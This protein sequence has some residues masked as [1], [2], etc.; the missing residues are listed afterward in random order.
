MYYFHLFFFLFCIISCSKKQIDQYNIFRY[1]EANSIT[2]LDPIFSNTQSNIWA[3]NQIFNTLVELDQNL[4]V[5]PSI[6]KKWIQSS[7]GLKYTFIIHDNIY[8]H[9]SHCFGN[10]STRKLVA[11]DF[12][13]SISRLYDKDIVSPGGW[14]LDYIDLENTYAINDTMIEIR[15]KQPFP[16][17]LGLLSMNYFSFTPYE[18]VEYY[19]D[20]F[21]KNP[22]G[23]GPFKFK[24]WKQNEKLI[25][26]KNLNYF[27]YE[28]NNR[29]PYLDG[30]AISFITQKE[31]VFMNLILGNFDFVSG[32]DSSFKDEFL[33]QNGELVSEYKNQFYLSKTPYLNTEYLGINIS[34]AKIESSLLADKNYRK[35]LNYSFDRALM[36][37]YLRN[38]IVTAA[39]SGIV[40]D[41]LS[42]CYNVDG[43]FYSPD[44]VEK[45]LSRIPDFTKSIT[46][47]T[48][49]DYLDVCEFIQHSASKFGINIDIEISSPAI[50]RE[51]FS[52]SMCDF[53]RA[54][55]IGDYPDPENF[56]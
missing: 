6:A 51:L 7:D 9:K 55:W 20:S 14:V 11:S 48:T 3:T 30:V 39:N 56:L 23:T 10:D 32:L 50:H 25:L 28:D 21:S 47:N 40:P 45:Y 49:Q 17:I 44:S 2:S 36:V 22:I 13:Y 41:I 53:F 31:S 52:S 8:Y 29:L 37:K 46:L 5:K 38:D 34:K 16:G 4:I 42:T 24:Y 43:Y 18:A 33:N 35:A 12:I 26:S 19:G 54:S 27:E 15:L 1:N